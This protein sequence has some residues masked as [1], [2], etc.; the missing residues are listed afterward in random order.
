[1]RPRI[2][3]FVELAPRPDKPIEWRASSYDDL[4]AF[5]D[6]A[7]RD[8]GFQLGLVQQ[9]YRP[10]DWKAMPTVGAG[11]IEIRIDVGTAYRVVIVVKFE[12]AIYVLHAFEKKSRRTPRPDV[13]LA[14]KRY[15]ELI[16]E[17]GQR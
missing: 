6:D 8:A 14:R 17:R 7:R 15:R 11:V 2:S 3:G 13:D 1:M 9:G 12:E 16:A 5:P 4:C 10:D